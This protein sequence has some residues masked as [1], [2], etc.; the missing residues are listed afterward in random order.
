[1]RKDKNFNRNLFLLVII[2]LFFNIMPTTVAA[3][4]NVIDALEDTVKKASKHVKKV[5]DKLDS[6][7]K[8]MSGD[9]SF[10]QSQKD[11]KSEKGKAN[12]GTDV[13]DKNGQALQKGEGSAEKRLSPKNGV[14]S[15]TKEN[16]KR[17]QQLDLKRESNTSSN[18]S[19][20]ADKE[21][22]ATVVVKNQH[23]NKTSKW[24][25]SGDH[26]QLSSG[27]NPKKIGR[28]TEEKSLSISTTTNDQAKNGEPAQVHPKKINHTKS[29][30]TEKNDADV[31]ASSN[32][33]QNL[34]GK[35]I[36]ET[37]TKVT[38]TVHDAGKL[39]SVH[40]DVGDLNEKNT[41]DQE[42]TVKLKRTSK[43]SSNKN[44]H[45]K[46]KVL[47]QTTNAVSETVESA[48]QMVF[49]KA[50]NNQSASK[51]HKD[52]SDQ[53]GSPYMPSKNQH[54][55]LI[56]TILKETTNTVNGAL[57]QVESAFY[58]NTNKSGER[59]SKIVQPE[60]IE[61]HSRDTLGRIIKESGKAVKAVSSPVEN[62]LKHTGMI[63]KNLTA[64]VPEIVDHVTTGLSGT[65]SAVVTAA[66]ASAQETF[67]L[68]DSLTLGL[69][70]TGGLE[71][72]INDT[73]KSTQKLIDEIGFGLQA[74]SDD[75]HQSVGAIAEKTGQTGSTILDS[76]TTT[77]KQVTADIGYA[78]N[79]PGYQADHQT[80]TDDSENNDYIPVDSTDASINIVEQQSFRPDNRN[81]KSAAIQEPHFLIASKH[82][83]VGKVHEKYLEQKNSNQMMPSAITD[84]DAALVQSNTT[85]PKKTDDLKYTLYKM[86][87]ASP[88]QSAQ[89]SAGSSSAFGAINGLVE[90]TGDVQRF[91]MEAFNEAYLL[92]DQVKERPLEDPP[93]PSSSHL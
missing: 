69:V 16:E 61:E 22:L 93:K 39:I 23:V 44:D 11:S 24:I 38:E 85:K 50:G 51:T 74:T 84:K 15:N 78:V 12:E 57:A 88:S 34:I 55:G 46:N 87:H 36:D 73:L 27:K 33:N 58:P 28:H 86:V 82:Q 1:M 53:K 30:K 8:S 4:D 81:R 49:G 63:V 41:A 52:V 83:S 31:T 14:K 19:Q 89:G 6:H 10:K 13:T 32:N 25:A 77:T 79:D 47:S 71:Q 72:G 42:K 62:T 90:W 68:A 65:Y 92:I 70:E 48:G 80:N 17:H 66:Q 9:G 29:S 45:Q 64:P 67:D 20:S 18:T 91:M 75:V 2:F 3:N 76:I 21:K 5:S 26:T 37:A 7:S 54:G 60:K 40:A 43:T 59:T 35:V 56:G